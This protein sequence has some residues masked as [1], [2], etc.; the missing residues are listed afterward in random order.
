MNT[1]LQRMLNKERNDYQDKLADMI[2]DCIA[3]YNREQ[4]Y[5]LRQDL[6]RFP[7]VGLRQFIINSLQGEM[8]M[9]KDCVTKSE[10]IGT[11][12]ENWAN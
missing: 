1:K 10:L 8:R 5:L 3:R 12:I 6:A 4:L 2:A 7:V 11:I 9:P